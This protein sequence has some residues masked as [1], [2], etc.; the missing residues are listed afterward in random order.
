MKAREIMAQ[1]VITAK[2]DTTLDEIARLMLTHNIGCV[3]VVDEQGQLCGIATESDFSAKEQGVPFS[4][5][6]LPRVFGQWM[7]REG[8]ERIYEAAKTMTVKEIMTVDVITL[9]EDDSVEQALTLMLKHGIH[10]I[11]VV[12]DGKPVGMLARHDLLKMMARQ[13]K[14]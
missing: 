4:T 3:V 8:I 11:P 1:P 12:R 2:Q 7:S 5:L 14:P 10:R 9:T 6:R 13:F